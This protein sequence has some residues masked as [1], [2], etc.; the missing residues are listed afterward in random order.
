MGYT[1]ADSRAA[2][3]LPSLA[4]LLQYH[5]FVMVLDVFF[6][7]LLPAVDA[8]VELSFPAHA[9]WLME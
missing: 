2:K 9:C 1:L 4:S 6:F 5:V 8:Q 3:Q 7:A